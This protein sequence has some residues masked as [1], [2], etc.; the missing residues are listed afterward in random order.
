MRLRRLLLEPATAAA[1]NN[2]LLLVLAVLCLPRNCDGFAT[3]VPGW[4]RQQHRLRW[5]KGGTE[6]HSRGGG[7]CDGDGNVDCGSAHSPSPRPRSGERPPR[8]TSAL[9]TRR[10]AIVA[11]MAGLSAEAAWRSAVETAALA[12]RQDGADGGA[13]SP[14]LPRGTIETIESGRAAVVPGWLPLRDCEELRSDVRR[15]YEGGH[16][17][18]FILSRNPNKADAAANDRWIMNSHSRATGRDG[19]FADPAVGDFDVRQRF[20]AR[21]AEVKGYLS[22][23]LSE[24]Q[25]LA[26]NNAATHEMEYLRYGEGAL[27]AR[28]TDEHHV[29]IQRVGGASLPKR[30]GAT[31]RSVTWM[32]Y[33]NDDWDG[34]VDGGHLRLHERSHPSS[35]RVGSRGQDLQVGWLR[36]MPS[37][38]GEDEPVFL[39]PLVADSHGGTKGES[40]ILYVMEDGAGGTTRRRDLSSKPFANVALH[41][42]GGDGVA[43]KIMVERLEDAVRFHL[44]DAPKSAV[45]SLLPPPGDAGLDGGER[46]RDIVP[47]AGTLVMFDSVS[48]PHE[49]MLT[50]KER[51]GIQGWFHEDLGYQA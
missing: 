6:I 43:R 19:P 40:C 51:Y 12:L 8:T 16:F 22:T 38:G 3:A 48:L 29:E 7:G 42:G 2:A 9:P 37:K 4:G 34:D 24:R 14:I 39:D 30:P 25:T 50:N 17:K 49:V 35:N 13:S 47:K 27:L 5:R 31:R 11:S 41:L 26:S 21:M 28:H 1:A 23:E 15:C 32:V 33:L 46:V 45:T 20:K 44:I 18:N 36:S 10:D